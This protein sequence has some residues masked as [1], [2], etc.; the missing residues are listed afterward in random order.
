MSSNLIIAQ[1][2]GMDLECENIESKQMMSH[3]HFL[4]YKLHFLYWIDLLYLE[5]W[6]FPLFQLHV[7]HIARNHCQFLTSFEPFWKLYFWSHAYL[8]WFLFYIQYLFVWRNRTLNLTGPF[9]WL[10]PVCG[11]LS[12]VRCVWLLHYW[13]SGQI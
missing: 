10:L 9:Q 8:D 3:F 5:K 1:E 4:C 7:L 13:L 11:M 2:E 6:Y 12:L